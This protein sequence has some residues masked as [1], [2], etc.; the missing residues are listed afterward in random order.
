[1]YSL[2]M[3]KQKLF[4]K[5]R[6]EASRISR[7][8]ADMPALKERK[9]HFRTIQSF[10]AN[11]APAKFTQYES[12]RTGMRA[13]VVDTKGPKVYGYFA[14]ATE[15]VDDSGAPHTLEHLCFMGSKSYKYKGVLDKLATRAYSNT[16]AWTA[17]DHTA[18]T[19]DT[20]GWDGFAQILPVYLEHVLFPTLTDAGCYT[21]VWHVDGE[22]NDAGVVYSEM[23]GVQNNSGELMELAARRVLY[24]D[25]DGF[26]YETG[27]MMEQ[28]R[29]LTADRIR[30]F[31]KDMY[32]PKNL[33]LVIIGEVDH[34]N[35][36]AI[37]DEFEDGTHDLVPPFDTPFIRPW[38]DSK[39]TPP[40]KESVIKTVQFPEDDESVGEILIGFL[41]PDCNDIV[42]TFAADI[43]LTYLAGSSVA[44]LE[45]VLVEKEQVCSAV[46]SYTETRPSVVTWFSLAAVATEKLAD[47]EK[48]F[49]E[50]LREAVSKP[51]D[52]AYMKECIARFKRQLLLTTESSQTVWHS[53][54][55]E[56]HLFGNRDGSD[57]HQV[58]ST[59]NEITT[60]EK[61]TDQEWRDFTSKWYAHANHVSIL[62]EPSKKLSKKLKADEKARVKAQKE[63]LGPGGLKDLAEKLDAAKAENDREIPPGVIEDFV[64]PGTE[65]IHF[66]PTTTARS[67]LA[68]KMGPL[69]NDIQKI[70]DNDQA[71]LPLFIHFEHIPSNFVHISLV[72]N[73]AS[74]PLEVK[75]LLTVYVANFFNTSIKR[76]GETIGFEEVVKELE[77]QTIGYSIEQGSSLGNPEL[78]KIKFSVERER[79]ESAVQWLKTM[80][81]DSI[82]DV[83]RLK[84]T[85]TKML[86]DIPEE[87][88][89]GDGMVAAANVLTHYTRESTV[90]ASTTLVKALYLKRINKLLQK[91]PADVIHLLE[92]I[93]KRMCLFS[94]FRVLVVA[95]IAKLPRPV[96]TW[97][98]LT[99][100][101][102]TTLSLTPINSRKDFLSDAGLHPGSVAYIIP[103][104]TIDSSFAH[105]RST[106]LQSYTDPRVPALMVTTAYLDAVEGP[107]WVAV[108]GTGLAY[109]VNFSYGYDTGALEFRIYRSPDTFKAYRAARTVIEDFISGKTAFEKSALEG[110]ISSIVVQFANEQPTMGAAANLAF[111][112][113]VIKGI[114]KDWS[115]EILKQVRNVSVEE[116]KEVLKDLLLPVFTPRKANVTITCATIMQ[117]VCILLLR[118]LGA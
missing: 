3:S 15:I 109:G 82:F 5:P 46:Y 44:L 93:R 110:A 21:E 56:D 24:P 9:S 74:V 72:I 37:L 104:P 12:E 91:E 100:S 77:A 99:K 57:L 67:G 17:T 105:F 90:R 102:D 88:R 1:M 35:L 94:N 38:V 70:I 115:K 4:V 47:V 34:E 78:L 84:A 52:M 25:G 59:L 111:A 76:D 87:K 13:V 79:Y 71:D 33:C 31:H 118:S 81:F 11:Y 69:D 6:L 95:D 50:L 53:S 32:Q 97:E 19:L 55:I 8:I 36:L 96:S 41:G 20:A 89:S 64:V 29:V 10:E 28:L 42:K 48:R 83:E 14:L 86:A 107:M 108:R 66:I 58:L 75:P 61:W 60:V 85:I 92:V 114:P 113:T 98:I 45:N 112:N 30:K 40:L 26:R 7:K 116:I 23:Q 16:N 27:G 62:G 80:L 43:L 68:K 101:L 106:G 103:M 73:T 65:S 117:E 22:G 51:F 18:Y 39:Q 49:F 63:R 2:L 54:I